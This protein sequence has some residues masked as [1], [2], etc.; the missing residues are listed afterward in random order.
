MTG[1]SANTA[2]KHRYSNNTMQ[3]FTATQILQSVPSSVKFSPLVNSDLLVV[4]MIYSA[5]IVFMQNKSLLEVY[6]LYFPDVFVIGHVSE[7][8]KVLM[9]SK[10]KSLPC[11]ETRLKI[12]SPP[13]QL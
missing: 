4:I 7:H 3:L 13:P 9:R 11:R 2:R 6:C 8:L 12:P 1:M 5:V 10:A